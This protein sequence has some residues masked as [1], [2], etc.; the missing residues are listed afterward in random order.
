MAV[1]QRAGPTDFPY[2]CNQTPIDLRSIHFHLQIEVRDREIDRLNALLSTEGRPVKALAQDCCYRNVK[3]LRDD[4]EHLQRENNLL[5]NKLAHSVRTLQSREVQFTQ[6]EKE[7]SFGGGVGG[8]GCRMPHPC[9]AHLVTCKMAQKSCEDIQNELSEKDKMIKQLQCELSKCMS[10]ERN[11]EMLDKLSDSLCERVKLQDC[12]VK[13]LEQH[14]N[15]LK[16]AGNARF[17]K[18]NC[19]NAVQHTCRKG[20]NLEMAD[21]QR[22]IECMRKELAQISNYSQGH[23]AVKRL[24]CDL[25][26][27]ECEINTLKNKNCLSSSSVLNT[28]RNNFCDSNRSSVTGT[29][30]DLC[31]TAA[32]TDRSHLER[33]NNVLAENLSRLTAERDHLKCLLEAELQKIRVEREA[34]NNTLDKLKCQLDQ[35]EREKMDL[36]CRQE[37]KNAAIMDM[38]SDVRKLQ[39]QIDLLRDENSDLKVGFGVAF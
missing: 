20:A 37:P 15:A 16:Q 28:N 6:A 13:K 21:I 30:T 8:S 7:V 29:S 32:H 23:D 4:V 17:A 31:R 2:Q 3:Q 34:F 27:K 35:V 38:K 26:S 1:A 25:A 5:R 33:D 19:E 24:Q 12:Y 9:E 14:Q 11:V 36:L 10:D 18:A 22:Q 39:C